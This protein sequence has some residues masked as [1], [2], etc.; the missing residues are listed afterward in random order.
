MTYS[1]FTVVL[2]SASRHDTEELISGYAG[3]FFWSIIIPL[4]RGVIDLRTVESKEPY[5]P[6]TKVV[7]LLGQKALDLVAPGERIDIVHGY[8]IIQ[9]DVVFLPTFT[10]Q[11]SFDRSNYFGEDEDTPAES[12]DTSVK[13]S[14]RTQR[15]N[16][17][18]WLYQDVKKALRIFYN[19]LR[20]V[21]Y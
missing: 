14:G 13:T 18:F 9:N 15:K 8:P 6:G 21:S 5:L 17:R 11:D 19:G 7:L 3:S 1:G 10:P 12:E 20:P 2:S 16:Y 4:H